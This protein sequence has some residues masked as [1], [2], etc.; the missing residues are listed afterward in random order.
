MKYPNLRIENFDLSS[1]YILKRST[2]DVS[3]NLGFVYA[4]SPRGET[5]AL[6]GWCLKQS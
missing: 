2:I 6:I 3:E 5:L 4:R 1:R